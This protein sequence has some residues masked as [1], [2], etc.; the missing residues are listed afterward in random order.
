MFH[1][2]WKKSLDTATNL[3]M[4]SNAKIDV[5]TCTVRVKARWRDT[6]QI[7]VLFM[8]VVHEKKSHSWDAILFFSFLFFL[9]VGVVVIVVQMCERTGNNYDIFNI[10]CNNI[11]QQQASRT[12]ISINQKRRRRR[13]KT[14]TAEP[15]GWPSNKTF[16]LNGNVHVCSTTSIYFRISKWWPWLNG[17]GK[18]GRGRRSKW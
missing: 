13:R 9:A 12:T 2:H 17:I 8:C 11:A 4:H 7:L 15:F 18:K 6:R 14:Y 10:H 5:K 1:P 3:I 16:A